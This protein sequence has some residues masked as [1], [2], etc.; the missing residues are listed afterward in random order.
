MVSKQLGYTS[1]D[2]FGVNERIRVRVERLTSIQSLLTCATK[3]TPAIHPCVFHPFIPDVAFVTGESFGYRMRAIGVLRAIQ[4]PPRQ[5]ASKVGD[6][7]PENL[8]GKY[9][10]DASLEIRNFINETLGEAVGDL[11]KEHSRFRERIKEPNCAVRP[12]IRS[13]VVGRP[14]FCQ[15]IEHPIGKLR[16]REHFVVRKIGYARQNIRIA[17]A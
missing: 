1:L 7:N 17:A 5:E 3:A 6:A 4:A 11:A 15:S 13:T 14:S 8:L 16:R 10:I 12:D 2:V 9:V